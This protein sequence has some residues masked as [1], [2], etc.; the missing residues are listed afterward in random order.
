MP[1]TQDLFHD[2]AAGLI[3][4]D[5]HSL[6]DASMTDKAERAVRT[7]KGLLREG[8]HFLCATSMGKDSSVMTAIFLR[9]LREVVEEDG[10][11]PFC[12]VVTSNTGIEQPEM[13]RYAMEAARQVQTYI[14]EHSLPARMDVVKPNLSNNY[15]VSILGGRTVANLPDGGAKCSDMMKVAPITRHKKQ[16]F[17]EFGKEK[18]CTLIG[19]R[20]DESAHRR[21]GMLARDESATTPTLNERGEYILSPIMHFTTDDVFEFIGYARNKMTESYSTFERL[22]ET[23]RGANAG[24]C[25]LNIYAAGKSN[26]TGCS[27][28]TGCSLCLRV[29]TDASMENFLK[30]PK[31]AYMRGLNDLREYIAATHY[32]PARR[33][34]I[35]RTTNADGTITISPVAY[36]PEHCIDLL[37]MVLSLDAEER[38]AAE[39]AGIAPRFQLLSEGDVL[40][41]DTLLNRYGYATGLVA[42]Y[43]Y[44]EIAFRGARFPIPV[45][46]PYPKKPF[47]EPV[48]VP[49]ADKHYDDVFSGLRDLEA[50]VVDVEWTMEKKGKVYSG[51]TGGPEFA[52]DEEAAMDFFGFEVDYALDKYCSEVISPTAAF[53]YLLRLGP[54]QIFKG[55]H[56]EVDRM[57][58]VASQIHR[59]DL[60]PILNDPQAL[61]R[62]LSGEAVKGQVALF[63]AA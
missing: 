41:V 16:V 59:S 28:R 13:D 40:A 53:H 61:I 5:A 20:L 36:S 37:K 63:D 23:Y 18:V 39:R 3:A 57:L 42:S 12:I 24:E 26:K 1:A 58:R 4:T 48:T 17:K 34:W 50:A 60:R 29:G 49:F 21:A 43:W 2:A 25:E 47:P 7:I 55:S 56:S 35:S 62:R 6:T 38:D 9:A 51:G 27:A 8:W 32:D 45:M 22:L 14:T 52:V 33:N 30:D 46:K 31:H 11:A 15:L 44:R 19:K 10:K 54:V